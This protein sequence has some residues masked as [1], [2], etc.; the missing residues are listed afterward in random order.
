MTGVVGALAQAL[1]HARNI[2]E[3]ELRIRVRR[4]QPAPGI[5]YHHRVGAMCNLL[6]EVLCY[7]RRVDRQHPMQQVRPRIEH[8]SHAREISTA[9]A[10]DHVAGE[11]EGAACEPEQRHA[12]MQRAFDRAHRIET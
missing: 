11:R 3:R 6:R 1:D 10:F 7:R 12:A 4:E 8:A 5:E 9:G 2:G